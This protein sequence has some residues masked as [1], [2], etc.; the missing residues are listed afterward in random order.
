[1]LSR[2]FDSLGLAGTLVIA[3][4]LAAMIAIII[5]SRRQGLAERTEF[6]EFAE[7]RG[8]RFSTEKTD[9][10]EKVLSELDPGRLWTVLH[11]ATVQ[12]SPEP[13]WLF[14]YYSNPKR[15]D[16]TE[17]GIGCMVETA[18]RRATEMISIHPRVPVL[19][20]LVL[21]QVAVGG[22]AFQKAFIVQCRQPQIVPSF[23]TSRLEQVL[24][25]HI[26]TAGW[27]M[28]TRIS[29]SRVLVSTTWA[30]NSEQWEYLVRKAREVR[31]AIW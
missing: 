4:F 25:D 14:A 21:N 19:E 24:M 16:D 31:D 8:W 11:F 5:L 30:R 9:Q 27:H 29:Q 18:G 22:A 10:V 17:R 20:K 26:A 12:E 2:I 7:T 6:R 1:M 13:G 28:L 3:L 23:V 15:G